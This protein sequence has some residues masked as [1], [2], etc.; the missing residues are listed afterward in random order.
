MD[1]KKSQDVKKRISKG[2]QGKD[3]GAIADLDM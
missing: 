1:G 2:V 3:D